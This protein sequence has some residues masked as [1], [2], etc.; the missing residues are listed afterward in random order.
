[1]TV[2][3]SMKSILLLYLKFYVC[4]CVCVSRSVMSDPMD[5]SPPV[6]SGH[7]IL[8]ARI[9]KCFAVSFS[10]ESSRPRDGIWVSCIADRFFKVWDPG[11]PQIVYTRIHF[12]HNCLLLLHPSPFPPLNKDNY[13][14]DLY[15]PTILYFLKILINSL[16][17]TFFSENNFMLFSIINM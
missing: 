12:K 10:R 14:L 11:K 5:C 1:M 8:Q 13:T 9:L 17:L 6:S 7:G 16:N 3:N 15:S 4:V 2:Q